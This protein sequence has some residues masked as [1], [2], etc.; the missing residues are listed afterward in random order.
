MNMTR[1]GWI[2]IFLVLGIFTRFLYWGHPSEVV[3]DEVHYGKYNNGYFSGEYFFDVHPPLGR[4]LIAGSAWLGGYDGDQQFEKIGDDYK[5]DKQRFLR[6]AP[7]IAGAL[8]PLI[9]YLLALEI[10]IAPLP[11]A[12]AGLAMLF[13]NYFI[14]QSRFILIDIFLPF[15][16]LL[17]LYWYFRFRKTLKTRHII[18]AAIF[19]GL[20]ISVKWSGLAFPALWLLFEFVRLLKISKF[21]SKQIWYLLGSVLIMFGIYYLIMSFHLQLLPKSGPGNA[22]MSLGFNKTLTDYPTPSDDIQPKNQWQKFTELN[23]QMF[24]SHEAITSSHPYS[25]T[26]DSWPFLIKPIYY[27]NSAGQKIYLLGNPIIW[28]L[29]T[30]AIGLLLIR[31]GRKGIETIGLPATVILAGFLVNLIPFAAISRTLFIYHYIGAYPFAILGLAYFFGSSEKM[32]DQ[33]KIFWVLVLIFFAAYVYF[34]PLTYGIEQTPRE[35][36]QRLWL[37]SWL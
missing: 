3:F 34:S 10:G 27:W 5:D 24:K 18:Y 33:R 15:F 6:M 26:W 2:I 13:E 35:F 25:S 12:L 36:E 31:A 37:K 8:L 9:I 19:G 28:W 29:S 4:L 11:S 14:V 30:V 23:V 32:K 21:W 1:K 7:M 16:G 20:T 22:F 17:T